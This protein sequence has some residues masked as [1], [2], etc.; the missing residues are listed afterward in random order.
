MSKRVSNNLGDWFQ[1]EFWKLLLEIRDELYPAFVHE[2]VDS[3]QARAMVRPQPSD[4][5]AKLPGW[6]NHYLEVKAS[7]KH[8]SLRQCFAMVRDT[9][10]SM[11]RDLTKCN[12]VYTVWF[13]SERRNQIQIWDGAELAICRAEGKPLTAPLKLLEWSDLKEEIINTLQ[14]NST[15]NL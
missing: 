11:A 8:E 14:S 7:E 1:K 6:S 3:K 12:C 5:M 10:L 13:Y 15:I 4:F 9:Q 2:F